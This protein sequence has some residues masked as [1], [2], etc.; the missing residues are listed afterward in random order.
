MKSLQNLV[1]Y[2]VRIDG[3]LIAL[4]VKLDELENII[5]EYLGYETK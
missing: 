2:N 4:S 3:V 5:L 1:V